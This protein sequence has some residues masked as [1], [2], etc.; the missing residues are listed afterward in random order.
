RLR[1]HAELPQARLPDL[2]ELLEPDGEADDAVRLRFGELD[3][4]IHSE[5]EGNVGHLETALGE[6]R[7]EGCLG[8]ARDPHEDEVGL[9]EVAWL[10][11]V[12]AL[13][14]ELHGLDTTEI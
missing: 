6:Q 10:L 5:H 9:L 14:R 1:G 13:D 11:P 2:A 7:R 3:R 8:G 12:V 4:R